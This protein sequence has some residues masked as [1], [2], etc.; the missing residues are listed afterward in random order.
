MKTLDG[1][2]LGSLYY[3]TREKFKSQIGSPSFEENLIDR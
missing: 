1:L 3:D 2:K